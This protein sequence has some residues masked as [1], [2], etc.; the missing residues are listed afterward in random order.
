MSNSL[1]PLKP[2]KKEGFKAKTASLTFLVENEV[3]N[4]NV[5]DI[6]NNEN[7]ENGIDIEKKIQN[8]HT[9]EYNFRK[10]NNQKRKSALR[11]NLILADANSETQSTVS[12]ST[13]SYNNY[14]LKQY[15]R[16]FIQTRQNNSNPKKN[17]FHL[18]AEEK[19]TLY[20]KLF[21]ILY[22]WPLSGKILQLFPNN[23]NLYKYVQISVDPKIIK[24]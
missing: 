9:R 4:N 24:K 7:S 14:T 10:M 19:K 20:N 17:L 8:K 6:N 3:N 1:D 5:P 18:I 23:K 12:T 11:R 15:W 21:K 13:A 2:K 22:I 16:R